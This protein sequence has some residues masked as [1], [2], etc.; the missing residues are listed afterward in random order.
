MLLLKQGLG[1]LMGL[2]L[3]GAVLELPRLDLSGAQH[4]L[5]LWHQ[6]LPYLPHPNSTQTIRGP[7]GVDSGLY[8]KLHSFRFAFSKKD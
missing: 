5:V 1:V 6:H 8:G 2:Y 4:C 7:I 3:T